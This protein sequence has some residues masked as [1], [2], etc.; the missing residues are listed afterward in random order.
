MTNCVE[1]SPSLEA[2]RSSYIQ[3]I[4]PILINPKIQEPAT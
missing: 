3:E 4:C 1:E 2:N